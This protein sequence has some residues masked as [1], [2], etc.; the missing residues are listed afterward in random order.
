MSCTGGAEA[1]RGGCTVN[2]LVAAILVILA[3]LVCGGAAQAYIVASW[4]N[5]W[6]E[7][8]GDGRPD[9]ILHLCE[10]T[11]YLN[12]Y[13]H[14]VLLSSQVAQTCRAYLNW[15]ANNGCTK[16]DALAIWNAQ[17]PWIA[18]QFKDELQGVSDGS[19]VALDDLKA[20][21]ALPARFHCCGF[22]VK[23]AA[24]LTGLTYQGH[25]LDYDT[26]IRDPVSG[27][28]IQENG[29][30]VIRHAE[31]TA[32]IVWAGFIGSVG[33]TRI[34]A[35]TVGEQGSSCTGE[36]LEGNPMVFQVREAVMKGNAQEAA[37]WLCMNRTA[38]FNFETSDA[39]G[40]IRAVEVAGPH[41]YY[42]G[43]ENGQ[44]NSPSHFWYIPGSPAQPNVVRRTNHFLSSQCRPFQ[45]NREGSEAHMYDFSELEID[46]R[47][48]QYNLQL[49][50]DT[51]TNTYNGN[52][53][54]L[55]DIFT[56]QQWAI[57]TTTGEMLLARASRD[58][59]AYA[60][61]KHYYNLAAEAAETLPAHHLRIPVYPVG[62]PITLRSNGGTVFCHAFVTCSEGHPVSYS[63]NACCNDGTWTTRTS[64]DAS[65]KAPKNTSWTTSQYH[66]ITCEMTC[67]GGFTFTGSFQVRVKSVLGL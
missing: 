34:G 20:M 4:S 27:R 14:G 55:F 19:G 30:I 38:G 26:A 46:P 32:H 56:E 42:I 53:A 5:S 41:A 58:K 2:K 47:N 59:Q 8:I 66:T 7:E 50:M 61:P 31:N 18:Q 12:G 28:Y 57:S 45:G 63:W 67:S 13:A 52:G 36:I 1:W 60:E 17:S 62:A 21:H 16:A 6:V 40:N 51:L 10:A 11:P 39:G 33:G 3:L 24:T 37:E 35:V 49:V 23:P 43:D 25:S 29:I 64:S 9:Q 48:G 15:G 22:A 54:W 65:W 44:E